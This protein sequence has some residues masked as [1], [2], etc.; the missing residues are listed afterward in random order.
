MTLSFVLITVIAV[1]AG[2]GILL[3]GA[4]GD[5]S[6]SDFVTATSEQALKSIKSAE[7]AGADVSDVIARFNIALDLQR[8]AERGTFTSC[9][10]YDEC[11]VQANDMMLAIVDDSSSLANQAT[12]KNQQAN[13][14][15]FTVYVPFGSFGASV[16]IV[17]V[18]RA[19]QHRRSE[20]YQEMDI[21]QKS[22][23]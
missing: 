5:N 1:L 3:A 18:Y 19:W 22:G 17:V 20:R 11:I 14:M 15:M 4:Q 13:V 12:A 6:G 23:H 7:A 8:Q 2:N 16:L 21:H 10:S 9:P